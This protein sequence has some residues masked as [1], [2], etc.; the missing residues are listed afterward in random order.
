LAGEFV[1]NCPAINRDSP[2]CLKRKRLVHISSRRSKLQYVDRNSQA[3]RL[4]ITG[5]ILISSIMAAL[6][7]RTWADAATG[8]AGTAPK[9]A[10]TTPSAAT[11]GV[12]GLIAHLHE[13]FQISP[14]QETLFQ[15]LAD[16]MRENADTMSMLTKKRVDNSK[17][18]TA[19]DDLKSYSE[20]S[21]AHA[22]GIKKMIPV[23]QAL[24]DS[25]SDAQ[26]K[27]ADNEFRE[28]YAANHRQK[29]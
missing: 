22:A 13:E 28:H 5:V 23:F 25:L 19:V 17:T 12:D 4:V 10:K 6:P 7:G 21:E 16:V 1:A 11:Q 27:A 9:T 15:K 3:R 8:Q 24:Y 2:V 26:K 29:H 18:S 14:T 20:I